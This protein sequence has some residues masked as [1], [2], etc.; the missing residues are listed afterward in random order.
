MQLL[1]IILKYFIH[2]F[3]YPTSS[4]AF[5]TFLSQDSSLGRFVSISRG[6]LI[7]QSNIGNYTYIG[8]NCK[9]ERTTIGSFCSIASDVT[10]GAASHPL[11]FVSTYPGFYTDKTSGARWFGK[12]HSFIDE[13]EVLIG[14]DVWIGTRAIILGGIIIADG[15]VIAAGA[16]VTK[17]VPPYA[18]VGGVPAKIIKYRFTPE[19]I[20]KLSNTEWWKNDENTLRKFS[21]H[22]TDPEKFINEIQKK[23]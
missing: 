9:F 19:I 14:S 12:F 22:I 6:C 17:D 16:V 20:S 3:K 11:D 5:G 4:V 21:E 10:C 23:Y 2:K 13:K 8:A 18:I 15:A 1:K 7:G